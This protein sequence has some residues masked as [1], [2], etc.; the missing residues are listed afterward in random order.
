M[1]NNAP[2]FCTFSLGAWSASYGLV[3]LWQIMHGMLMRNTQFPLWK[4]AW[5]RPFQRGVVT[6]LWGATGKGD[7][8]MVH[9][10]PQR[11]YMY[12][13]MIFLNHFN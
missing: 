7:K 12:L 9:Q 1:T 5:S 11:H 6:A 8:R 13:A 3:G 4:W 10:S 2:H